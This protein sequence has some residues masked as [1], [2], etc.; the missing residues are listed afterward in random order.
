MAIAAT[1]MDTCRALVIAT[2]EY[3]AFRAALSVLDGAGG[4]G[5]LTAWYICYGNAQL[6]LS[7]AYR[8]RKAIRETIAA[9]GSALS[10]VERE[11]AYRSLDADLVPIHERPR[12]RAERR[13]DLMD[14]AVAQM[15][16]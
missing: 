6:G 5:A 7:P 13:G 9:Q 8:L 16:E 3:T 15:L 2:P 14:L 11:E 1:F 4:N 10:P 12:T